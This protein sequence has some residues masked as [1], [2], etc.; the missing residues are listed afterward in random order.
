MAGATTAV[1]AV[2]ATGFHLGV[3]LAGIGVAFACIGV[4][5]AGVGANA[6]LAM[7]ITIA[8]QHR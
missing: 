3:L 8:R 5:I 6:V 2:T 7:R 4:L 1:G